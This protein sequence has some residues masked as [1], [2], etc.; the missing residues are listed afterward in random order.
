MRQSQDHIEQDGFGTPFSLPEFF[1][2]RF[3]LAV[4]AFVFAGLLLLVAGVG[5]FVFQHKGDSADDIKI[6]SDSSSGQNTSGIMVHVDGAVNK[7]GVYKLSSDSR[8]N[9][10]IAA[11]GGLISGANGAKI[12]LAAKV[13]DGQKVHIPSVNDRGSS[14]SGGQVSGVADTVSEQ[15][16]NINTA[17][18]SELDKLPGVG[19]V[20]A[21]KIIGGRPYASLDELVSKKAVGKATFEKLKDLISL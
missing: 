21:G 20:T 18:E 4:V 15:G 8:V 12:N 14:G 19:P 1:K 7:P 10:A 3:N 11:A 6:I 17:S 16:I 13:S 5:L 9:D 2:N